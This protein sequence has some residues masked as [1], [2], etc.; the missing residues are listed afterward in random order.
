MWILEVQ[1][2]G[3][4]R[5]TPR[6]ESRVQV[7]CD[8][9]STMPVE[10]LPPTQSHSKLGRSWVWA[11]LHGKGFGFWPGSSLWQQQGAQPQVV[12]LHHSE[13]C[14]RNSRRKKGFSSKKGWRDGEED[15]GGPL[16]WPLYR[17]NPILGNL[18]TVRQRMLKYQ[19]QWESPNPPGS[20]WYKN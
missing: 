14:L 3:L 17:P 11:A 6:R 12:S 13:H 10:D 20:W 7:N 16:R 18:S 15:L 5:A 4:S 9:L 8:A 19:A 1:W 2:E